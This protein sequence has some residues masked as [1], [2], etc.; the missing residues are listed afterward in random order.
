MVKNSLFILLMVLALSRCGSG[1]VETN[2]SKAYNVEDANNNQGIEIANFDDIFL[3]AKDEKDGVFNEVTVKTLDQNKTFSWIT[4]SNP[5]YYPTI[6]T[7]DINGDGTK[8]IVIITTPSTGSDINIQEL[9]VLRSKDLMELQI[10]DPLTYINKNIKS[11]ISKSHGTVKIL[12]QTNSQKLDKVFKE[13]DAGLWFDE[14]SFNNHIK[15]ELVENKITA[16]LLGTASP[17]LVVVSVKV[18]YDQN[19][20]AIDLVIS[21]IKE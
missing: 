16:T 1:V 15:Y 6:K 10:D 4:D 5:T 21:D 3:L 9:H 13:E 2:L 18:D 17:S 12:I 19:L 8:E 11:S 7:A 20:K 14:V